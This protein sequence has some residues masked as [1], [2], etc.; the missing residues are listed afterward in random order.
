MTGLARI[1]PTKANMI[2][3]ERCVI[4]LT[5]ARQVGL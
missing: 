3:R 5:A 1:L 2:K 4:K